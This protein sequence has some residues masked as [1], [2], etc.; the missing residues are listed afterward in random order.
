MGTESDVSCTKILDLRTVKKFGFGFV[1]SDR[2]LK[3]SADVEVDHRIIDKE[4]HF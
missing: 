1:N 3:Q 2:F 4:Q